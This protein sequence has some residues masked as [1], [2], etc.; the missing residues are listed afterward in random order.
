MDQRARSTNLKQEPYVKVGQDKS[1]A[2]ASAANYYFL[3]LFVAAFVFVMVLAFLYDGYDESPW[4]VATLS[5]IASIVSFILFRETVLR[6]SRQ[7]EL[8]ARRLA[9]HL[10]TVRKP[11]RD[12]E[13]N[14]KLSLERNEKFLREIRSKSDAAKVLGNLAEA[15]KEVYE[16][17]DDY[18]MIASREISRARVGS[19][20]I[21]AMRK[22]TVSAAK[23]HRFHMLKWAELKSRSFTVE[24]RNARSVSDRI[25]AAEEALDAVEKA[26]EVYP[27][28]K[29]LIDSREVLEIFLSSTRLR[30]VL[31]DAESAEISGDLQK[32]IH[33][34]DRVLAELGVDG[35]VLDDHEAVRSKILSEVERIR[36][37]ME[38]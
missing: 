33:I 20:R 38:N 24:A 14:D 29:T 10:R 37:L 32:A 28:E 19:P 7:R 25:G 30:S 4:V 22:G 31:E 9:H 36:R 11:G 1:G 23:R 3:A 15:H 12:R 2:W 34:Y 18:L 27:G 8:A 6:R 13:D 35:Q 16:L 26:I 17:C 21:P 5:S